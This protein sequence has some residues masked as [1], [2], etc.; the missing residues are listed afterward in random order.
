MEA[1]MLL[2][3]SLRG[4]ATRSSDSGT[5][6]VSTGTLRTLVSEACRQH[7]RQQTQCTGPWVPSSTMLVLA[8]AQWG[9]HMCC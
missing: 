6:R 3:S 8:A 5:D 1:S 2:I 4:G 9:E 7:T